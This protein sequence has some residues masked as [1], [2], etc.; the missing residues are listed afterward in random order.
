LLNLELRT[1]G[2]GG[3][4]PTAEYNVQTKEHCVSLRFAVFGL[5]AKEA[6]FPSPTA[7]DKLQNNDTIFEVLVC[8]VWVGRAIWKGAPHPPPLC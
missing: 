3:P 7:E 6:K 4:S 5:G 8:R 2:K 1:F